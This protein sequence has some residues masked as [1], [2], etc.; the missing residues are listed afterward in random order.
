[1]CKHSCNYR[2]THWWRRK[3][4]HKI[5]PTH[6]H[7]RHQQG[8]LAPPFVTGGKKQ[9]EQQQKKHNHVQ[10]G[11]Y[12]DM[13]KWWA[14]LESVDMITTTMQAPQH[15]ETADT[16]HTAHSTHTH[17]HT[18]CTDIRFCK[19]PTFAHAHSLQVW[20][21]VIYRVINIRFHV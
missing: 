7:V 6:M 4:T 15:E 21:F 12:A 20:G 11:R 16:V 9:E 8:L 5:Q 19:R 18:Q 1:M 13:A 10:T 3:N 14:T 17:T 2:Q